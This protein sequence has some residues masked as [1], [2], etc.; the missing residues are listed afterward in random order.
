MM[1][2]ILTVLIEMKKEV[3]R[4]AEVLETVSSGDE[5][6]AINTHEIEI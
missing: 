5:S 2:E 6:K 4:I 1:K 3:A